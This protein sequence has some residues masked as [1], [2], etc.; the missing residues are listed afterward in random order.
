MSDTSNE[1]DE[2]VLYGPNGNPLAFRIPHEEKTTQPAL[3]E[4]QTKSRKPGR[5]KSIQQL[6]RLA[7]TLV[8]LILGFATLITLWQFVV[9]EPEIHPIDF[10]AHGQFQIQ[11][12]IHNSLLTWIYQVRVRGVPGALNFVPNPED[13]GTPVRRLGRDPCERLNG[14]PD[15]AVTE[16][17]YAAIEPG[18]DR[19][20]P[21]RSGVSGVRM[22]F[23]VAVR[24]RQK[25]LGKV[26]L[27]YRSRCQEFQTVSD[28][29][30]RTHLVPY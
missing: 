21:T 27:W 8:A 3:Q 5:I 10:G 6:L 26:P 13:L 28:S 12:T 30:G 25:L 2:P 19:A 15:L 22:V 29:E 14:S 24:Y 1:K 18:G 9:V 20:F 16:I 11:F 17:N 7:K 4:Q 23:A